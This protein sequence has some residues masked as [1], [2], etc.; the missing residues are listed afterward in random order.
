MRFDQ[1]QWHKLFP[2][3]TSVTLI[4]SII[5][6]YCRSALAVVR[7]AADKRSERAAQPMVFEEVLTQDNTN[8][9]S[10]IDAL[11][12]PSIVAPISTQL[13]YAA[14]MVFRKPT[15]RP[16]Q[17]MAVTK[18]VYDKSSQGKLL[19]VD[20][21]GGGKSLIFS[22]AAVMVGGIIYI[23]IPLLALTANQMT[24]LKEAISDEG[25]IFLFRTKDRGHAMVRMTFGELLNKDH[26][27]RWEAITLEA[28][29]LN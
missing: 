8:D 21:T 15:L 10:W 26:I 28:S 3:G 29:G 1:P 22:L 25:A 18:L 5:R 27:K 2:R 6:A 14:A 4:S 23:I 16:R 20:R 19:V 17:E 13:A 9:E 11:Q 24:K 7:Q 12:T